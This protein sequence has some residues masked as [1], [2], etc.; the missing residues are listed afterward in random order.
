M[1]TIHATRS[2]RFLPIVGLLG[3]LV[4]SVLIG[5]GR[6]N[7]QVDLDVLAQRFSGEYHTK[8]TW[9][10]DPRLYISADHTFRFEGFPVE[11]LPTLGDAGERVLSCEGS[12][13]ADSDDGSLIAILS[14]TTVNGRPA[15]KSLIFRF[16]STAL[17][18]SPP[19]NQIAEFV[20]SHR[21]KESS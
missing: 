10:S 18:I 21:P 16:G 8:R 7:Q 6:S 11:W 17:L 15:S 20:R 13:H 1:I 2:P 5:C 14:V 19:N 9:P 12:W 4:G 3:T